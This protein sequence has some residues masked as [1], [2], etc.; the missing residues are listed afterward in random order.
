M[1]KLMKSN[2]NSEL[3]SIGTEILLGE[4]TDTNSV[5]LAKTLRDYGINVFYMTSVGDNH[6]RIVQVIQQ[7]MARS[8][9]VVTCGGLGPTVDDMTRQAVAEAAGRE[10]VFHETLLRQIEERFRTFKMRMSE[11][12]RR[13]AYLPDGAIVIE[14]SVGT[15]PSFIVEH[16]GGIVISLPGVPREMKFLMQEQVIPYL[17]Q[18][19]NLGVIKARVLHTAGIGESVLDELI[20][21]ALLEGHNPTLG[22]AAHNGQVDV[23]V[24][25]KA[26]TEADADALIAP[27][28]EILRTKAGQWIYGADKDTLEEVFAALVRQFN[29]K[30]ALIDTGLGG[31]LES[32]LRKADDT[33]LISA[34]TYDHPAM[35]QARL[36]VPFST[37]RELASAAVVAIQNQTGAAIVIAMI[38]DPEIDESPDSA[39]S[40]AVSVRVGDQQRTRVYG[41][42]AKSDHVRTWLKTWS[43][44]QAWS[45]A[46]EIYSA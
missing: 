18:R 12:N 4:I 38:S 39:E 23:R 27:I 17:R 33:I 36:Q 30:V 11:N 26:D 5:Y 20:G 8:D 37:M 6:Q 19:F 22:L 32:V 34:E 45:M 2:V 41:F 14:N 1:R 28:E 42:G 40:T 24:T 16:E 10:L 25:A 7:A 43:L 3:I 44:A 46:K 13:Q 21:T 29:L 15:A 35:L 9:L 31:A